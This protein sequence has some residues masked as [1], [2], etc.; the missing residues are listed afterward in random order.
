MIV[1]N[2]GLEMV[3]PVLKHFDFL[4]Q[5]GELSVAGGSFLFPHGNVDFIFA[6][7]IGMDLDVLVHAVL[8][9]VLE[10]LRH[11]NLTVYNT[12]YLS[13]SDKH[14]IVLDGRYEVKR[15]S[16]SMSN[17]SLDQNHV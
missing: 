8:V 5:I 3:A 11:S 6:F 7:V 4:K 13:I 10:M 2:V 9:A 15:D 16:P 14:C 12:N 1:L 17:V